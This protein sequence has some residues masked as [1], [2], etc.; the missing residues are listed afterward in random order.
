M[1]LN[2]KQKINN[3]KPVVV[4]SRCLGF[5]ACRYDGKMDS[6]H[7]IEK[8]KEFVEIITVCPETQ[9]GLETPRE[10]IRLVKE[11][12][13]APL[14][15]LQHKTE[16]ELS[17]EMIEFGE[18]FLL[19]LPKVDGF[20]LKSRSPS[21]GIKDVKIALS[22]AALSVA[23]FWPARSGGASRPGAPVMPASPGCD[24]A[25][26][27]VATRSCVGDVLG[28][29]SVD[30]VESPAGVAL[31]ADSGPATG[32]AAAF[33]AR[34][35][36]AFLARSAA[37]ASWAAPL[38]A[39]SFAALSAARRAADAD[40]RSSWTSG[41]DVT[42]PGS[43]GATVGPAGFLGDRLTGPGR[44][45]GPGVTTAGAVRIG[46]TA[47]GGA[48]AKG[49]VVGGTTPGVSPPGPGLPKPGPAGAPTAGP[50]DA[51]VSPSE[52]GAP[53]EPG[54]PGN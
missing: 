44:C 16:R 8:L 45:T 18:K 2:Y 3:V 36:A 1:K 19:S 22:I 50:S 26:G 34:S 10:T 4:V 33:L 37:A 35:A 51:G 17:V 5:E 40:L 20:I 15:L 38:R 43:V 49:S 7:L 29:S 13:D 31:L 25:S 6:C 41:T 46:G 48:S 24:L 14:K 32:A 23:A 28:V 12:E 53:S 42:S 9:I 30:R 27:T 39:R 47:P 11:N 21:C 52:P 54:R